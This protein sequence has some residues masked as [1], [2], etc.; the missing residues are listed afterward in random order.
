MAVR[1]TQNEFYVT[2]PEFYVTRHVFCVLEVLGDDGMEFHVTIV[3]ASH[4]ISIKI[5]RNLY[6][7]KIDNF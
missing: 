6:R 3:F 7:S 4:L 5:S 2:D 1:N